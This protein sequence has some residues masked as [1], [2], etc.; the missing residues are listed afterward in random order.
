MSP[1]R[2]LEAELSPSDLVLEFLGATERLT[3]ED[4]AAVAGV[5]AATYN[6]WRRQPPRTLRSSQ[7]Q[8]IERY[9]GLDE[10]AEPEVWLC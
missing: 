5:S 1:R 8:R 2:T 6:R 9:L 3:S 7:R 10:G 4:A